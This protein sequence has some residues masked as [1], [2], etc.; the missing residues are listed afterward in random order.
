MVMVSEVVFQKALE[1]LRTYSEKIGYSTAP[2]LTFLIEKRYGI[3]VSYGKILPF[4]NSYNLFNNVSREYLNPWM[5]DAYKNEGSCTRTIDHFRQPRGFACWNNRDSK[6]NCDNVICKYHPQKAAISVPCNFQRGVIWKRQN[7]KASFVWGTNYQNV[8]KEE[9]LKGSKI[10]LDD[11]LA[12]FYKNDNEINEK[13]SNKFK[14]EFNFSNAEMAEFFTDL[15]QQSAGPLIGEIKPKSVQTISP[16]KFTMKDFEAFTGSREDA[17]YIKDRLKEFMAIIKPKLPADLTENLWVPHIRSRGGSYR[18]S[19]WI[20]TS[21]PYSGDPRQTI[22]IQFYMSKEFFFIGIWGEGPAKKARG[23]VYN[24]VKD[25]ERKFLDLLTELPSNHSIAINFNS[26]IIEISKATDANLNNFI[27]R[28]P[29][30]NNYFRIGLHL[31]PKE[32]I[33]MGEDIIDVSVSTVQR[34]LDLYNF[35]IGVDVQISDPIEQEHPNKVAS[36]YTID[37]FI[38]ETG[39]GKEEIES[40]VKLLLRKKQVIFQG[41]PGTGKTFIALRL[42]KILISGTTGLTDIVQFHPDYSYEDFIQGY[43]P[44][45]NKGVFQ[46]RLKSG[47]F[48]EFC[49]KAANHTNE[50][51]CVL[52]VDEINRANLARVFGEL[53]YLLEHRAEK[54]PLAAGGQPFAIPTNVYLIGTMNTADRSIALV[55]HA[56]RRRFCF[57]RVKPQYDILTTYLK[58]N[59]L[60]SDSLIDV[61]RQINEAIE[62]PNYELGISFF[63]NDNSHLKELLPSIWKSEI[64]PYLEEFFYD[65]PSK[66]Q[67]FRWDCLIKDKLKDW[68]ETSA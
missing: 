42:A 30:E 47:R 13:T 43:F 41:P 49:N 44:E 35:L 34:L 56:L 32:T 51:P 59:N 50:A 68:V 8:V 29:M 45:Q 14:E 57:V 2:F 5:R 53:M 4:F 63:M 66:V 19:M 3:P 52:I 15:S 7:P 1:N 18:T 60:P 10:P 39:F 25:N 20:G 11:L 37:D 67:S 24:T 6:K 12:V 38:K 17:S 46:F 65:Q 64:E 33:N 23:K 9:V 22:Q 16:F 27:E 62:D 48:V 40:W 36:T 31:T 21:Y 55:D 26:D 28:I 61:L 58:N 54:I